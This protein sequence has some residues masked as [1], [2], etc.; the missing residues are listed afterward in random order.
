MTMHTVM[1]EWPL[2]DSYPTQL[3]LLPP[4]CW[5]EVCRVTDVLGLRHQCQFC[6][7]PLLSPE[8]T[9]SF[10]KYIRKFKEQK[11]NL[12]SS[13]LAVLW[14]YRS[15]RC[16]GNFGSELTPAVSGKWDCIQQL[17][18]SQEKLA[19]LPL[20]ELWLG[21]ER[22]SLSLQLS[23]VCSQLSTVCMEKNNRYDKNN[24]CGCVCLY[25]TVL[26]S[27]WLYPFSLS[28]QEWYYFVCLYKNKNNSH[29]LPQQGHFLLDYK[30]QQLYLF[31]FLWLVGQIQQADWNFLSIKINKCPAY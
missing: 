15:L 2:A 31:R 7:S 25:K 14:S 17:L 5:V 16:G 1:V 23:V 26:L 8:V 4:S 22:L 30:L 28:L 11:V 19:R 21:L 18:H 29:C 12:T 10:W 24:H 27:A 9:G 20:Q 13:S 6:V 3:S